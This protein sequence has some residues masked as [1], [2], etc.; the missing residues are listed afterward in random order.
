MRFIKFVTMF[1]VSAVL[2]SC[3][4]V[5]AASNKSYT[6]TVSDP[7]QVPAGCMIVGQTKSVPPSYIVRCPDSVPTPT[8]R[9]Y[10]PIIEKN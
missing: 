7:S 9:V 4:T 6:I 2:V 10:A 1:A 5:E 8:G 3:A